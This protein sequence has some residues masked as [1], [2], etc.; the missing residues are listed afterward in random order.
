[1]TTPI[2]AGA[3]AK[4]VLPVRGRWLTD[5]AFAIGVSRGKAPR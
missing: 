2:Q 3:R 5:S 4:P 1:M